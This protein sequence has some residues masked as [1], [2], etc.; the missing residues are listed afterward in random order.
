MVNKKKP[1]ISRKGPVEDKKIKHG[2]QRR[3]DSVP[4]VLDQKSKVPDEQ[5]EEKV[6]GS[7]P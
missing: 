6:Q 5:N 7:R 1:V 4:E 3:E 2:A